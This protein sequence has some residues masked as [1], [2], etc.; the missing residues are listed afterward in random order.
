MHSLKQK[1][2]AHFEWQPPLLPGHIK[3][4]HVSKHNARCL[5]DSCP[6]NARRALPLPNFGCMT[7]PL[8][9]VWA[10]LRMSLAKFNAWK[11]PMKLN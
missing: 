6:W 5:V 8:R 1:K 2:D 11:K 7:W 10:S 3:D 9:A 4:T